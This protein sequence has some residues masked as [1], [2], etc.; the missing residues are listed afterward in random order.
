MSNNDVRKRLA[1]AKAQLTDAEAEQ[2]AVWAKI[3]A[4]KKLVDGY[5]AVIALELGGQ[6]A[7][8]EPEPSDHE[9]TPTGG[10]RG[11]EAV[12]R[13]MAED[14]TRIWKPKEIV[15]AIKRRGWFEASAKDPD[16]AIRIAARR[17]C[18]R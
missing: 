10:P 9:P 3:A 13:I 2:A 15:E 8:A 6:P 4:Y 18:R 14:P 5:E 11:R 1:E 12:R 16:A 17:T 7:H